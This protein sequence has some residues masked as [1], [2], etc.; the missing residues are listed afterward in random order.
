MHSVDHGPAPSL[1]VSARPL[2]AI[3]VGGFIVGILDLAYAIL[4]YSPK[5]PILIAQAIASGV[6]GERSFKGGVQT[7]ALGVVLHFFIA[8]SVAAVYYVASR[9]L[10]F[11]LQNA[12]ICGV[13]YGAL[14]YLFMHVVV[15]PLS[16]FPPGNMPLIYK[17]CEFVEHLVFVGPPVALS[18]RH[19]SKQVPISIE[20]RVAA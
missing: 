11:L 4:V 17:I 13:T 7:A 6:L 20:R 16:A 19:Y 18:V 14:V 9:K 1:S 10:P 2:E 15:L 5:Q 8:F 3:G 12:I